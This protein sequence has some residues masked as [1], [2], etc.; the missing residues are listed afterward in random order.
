MFG[1]QRAE[2]GGASLET[3]EGGEWEEERRNRVEE[4]GWNS[5]A[6]RKGEAKRGNPKFSRKR[7][8]KKVLSPPL[9]LLRSHPST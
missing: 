9:Y 7:R 2:D 8:G 4:M 1:G 6:S 3:G 5:L